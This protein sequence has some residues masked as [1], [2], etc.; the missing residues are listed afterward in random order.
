MIGGDADVN[1]DELRP[2]RGTIGIRRVKESSLLKKK[3]DD[4][5]DWNT[6]SE[7]VQS[8]EKKKRN[9]SLS[10]SHTL[11]DANGSS[12]FFVLGCLS[13]PG[14]ARSCSIVT[15]ITVT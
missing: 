5:H 1:F 3:R 2:S 14:A 9:T 11:V 4:G 10:L 12:Y 15:D 6:K 8:P 13:S 7:G